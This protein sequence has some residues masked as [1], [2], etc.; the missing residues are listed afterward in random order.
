M[1]LA[2]CNSMDGLESIMLSEICQT[3]KDKYHMTCESKKKANEKHK[4]KKSQIQRIDCGCRGNGKR[5]MS[6]ISEGD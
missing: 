6:E 1:N 2:V 3:E 5:G 4:K